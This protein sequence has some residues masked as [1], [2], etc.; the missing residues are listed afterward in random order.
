MR[1]VSNSPKRTIPARCYRT[2]PRIWWRK[3]LKTVRI[4]HSVHPTR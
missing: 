3:L 4:V 1:K 2:E